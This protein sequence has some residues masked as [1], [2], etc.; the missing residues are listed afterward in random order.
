MT[1]FGL[2]Y[3][4]DAAEALFEPIGVP[5]QVVVD[6]QMCALEVDAFAGGVGSQQYFYQRVVLE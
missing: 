1:D 4:M 5:G 6:H 3:A 2:T